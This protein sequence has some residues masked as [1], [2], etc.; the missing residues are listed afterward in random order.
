MAGVGHD[1]W[2]QAAANRAP[3]RL[4]NGRGGTL[5]YVAPNSRRC[6]VLV[7]GRHIRVALDEVTLL[8]RVAAAGAASP[9]RCPDGIPGPGQVPT[10]TGRTTT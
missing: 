1:D 8:D 6:K 4:A 9:G 5:L 2:I 7:G 3:I 10:H